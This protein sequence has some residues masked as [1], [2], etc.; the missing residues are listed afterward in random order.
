LCHARRLGESSLW[1]DEYLLV[2]VAHR[3]VVLTLPKRLRA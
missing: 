2:P 1:P 3:Q